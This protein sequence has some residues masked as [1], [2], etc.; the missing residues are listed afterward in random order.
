M[1]TGRSG[2]R[3]LFTFNCTIIGESHIKSKKVCQ[4][5]SFSKVDFLNVNNSINQCSIAIVADGHGSSDYFRSGTGS[6]F[7]CDATL[8][9]LKIWLSEDDEVGINNPNGIKSIQQIE[10]RD[11]ILE[12]LKMSI[13]TLW[14]DKIKEDY[15]SNPFKPEEIAS[16]S[17]KNRRKYEE[18]KSRFIKAYGTTLIVALRHSKFWIGL[19]IGD[20]KCV[21]YI[22]GEEAKQPIPWDERCFLNVTTS[23]SDADALIGFRHYY[24]DSLPD[25]IY[26]ATDGVDDSY[27][28]DERLH[29]FYIRLTDSFETKGTEKTLNELKNFLPELSKKGSGDDISIAGIISTNYYNIKQA[30]LDNKK[31]KNRRQNRLKRKKKRK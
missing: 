28:S 6:K 11:K 21:I 7:A 22:K 14:H 24:G 3:S 23:M 15:K 31:N 18:D 5:F 9:T 10:N 12:Q 13:I 20:G 17:D 2:N 4:D 26:I 25:A 1:T 29:N 8:E 27:A 30:L 16:M 19:Q